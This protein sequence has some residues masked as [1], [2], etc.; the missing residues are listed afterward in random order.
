MIGNIAAPMPF[1]ASRALVE[2]IYQ[3]GRDHIL[4][5]SG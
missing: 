4:A 2:Q 1:L 3:G 5:G